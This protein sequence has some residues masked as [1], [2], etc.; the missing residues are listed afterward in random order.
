[1]DNEILL[2]LSAEQRKFALLLERAPNLRGFWDFEKKECDLGA[3]RSAIGYLST[4]EC[5]LLTFYTNLWLGNNDFEF[6][7]DFFQAASLGADE[8]AIISDWFADPFWP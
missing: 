2:Q 7:F 1:M 8:K 6:D 5:V 4:G 3:I